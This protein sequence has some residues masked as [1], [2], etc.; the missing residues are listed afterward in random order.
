MWKTFHFLHDHDDNDDHD[1]DH[2]GDHEDEDD[3]AGRVERSRGA[4]KL[5]NGEDERRER[6]HWDRG[7][8]HHPDDDEDN[9]CLNKIMTNTQNLSCLISIQLYHI[10]LQIWELFVIY[11]EDHDDGNEEC[12]DDDDADDLN[13]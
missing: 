10:H 6:D 13:H 7:D 5:L 3:V 9:F 12:D 1:D 2:D 11:I 4:H 8:L